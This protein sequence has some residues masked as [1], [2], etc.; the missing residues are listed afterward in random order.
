[1]AGLLPRQ[2]LI[3][4]KAGDAISGHF[5]GAILPSVLLPLMYALLKYKILTDNAYVCISLG[6]RYHCSDLTTLD[7]DIRK[8][9][10]YSSVNKSN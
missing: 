9:G 3:T 8:S 4:K 7:I 5:A 1:M 10:H 2:N 6:R